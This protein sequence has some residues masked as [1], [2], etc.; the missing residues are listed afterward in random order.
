LKGPVIG[1]LSLVI[2]EDFKEPV[3]SHWSLGGKVSKV[4]GLSVECH[5]TFVISHWSMVNGED[6][7]VNSGDFLCFPVFFIPDA[8]KIAALMK[9]K[10]Y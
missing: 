3:I 6:A 2:W 10:S 9:R 7:L 4:S 1:H 8:S 5:W